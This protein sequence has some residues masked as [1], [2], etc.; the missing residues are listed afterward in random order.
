[1]RQEINLFQPIFRREKKVFS[2]AAMLQIL[3]VVAVALGV[4]YAYGQ[5]QLASARA[6]IVRLD[7]RQQAATVQ[8]GAL[9]V[10]YPEKTRS[11]ALDAEVNRLRNEVQMRERLLVAL[12]DGT[13]GNSSGLSAYLEALARQSVEGAWLTRFSLARGGRAIGLAGRALAPELVPVYVRRLANEPAFNG[14]AFSELAIRRAD[15]VPAEVE[16][17]LR[18]PGL[19]ALGDSGNE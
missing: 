1:M 13:L 8:V 12:A 2:A 6:E 15:D 7:E 5:W 3:G 4:I 11:Q 16:F 10:R 14:R 19:P 9:R 18:T 17:E